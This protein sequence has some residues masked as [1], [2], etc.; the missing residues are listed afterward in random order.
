MDIAQICQVYFSPTGGVERVTAVLAQE[1]G[2]ALGAPVETFDFTL[3][4]ARTGTRRYGP[5]DLVVFGTPVYAGLVPNKI[6]PFVQE[7]FLGEGALAVPVAVFGNRSFDD[8][9]A[10]LRNTLEGRGFHTVAGAAV[11][12]RHAFSQTLAAGRPD[13]ADLEA[14]R[15]FARR[16]ADKVRA[17]EETPPP[18]AVAGRDPV[19]PYYTPLGLDG[20]PAVFLKAKPKTREDLCLRCGLCARSCPM[21]SISREDPARV[22]GVCIKCQACVRRCP[23]GAKYFDD[24]AFL[25][26]KAMLEQTYAAR[27]EPAFFL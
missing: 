18:V 7:G 8:A 17:A 1:L 15:A 10:E 14:L 21:G 27:K 20:Q 12:A 25:S 4:Q 22:T 19:G 5:G 3:P 24:P 2:R 6:L 26:H 16:T 13:G 23:A 11:A 9:L